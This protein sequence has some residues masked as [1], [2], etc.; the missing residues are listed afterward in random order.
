[1]KKGS[2]YWGKSIPSWHWGPRRSSPVLGSQV[3][4]FDINTEHK[5]YHGVGAV[6]A[7]P[8]CYFRIQ[9][10]ETTHSLYMSKWTWVRHSGNVCVSWPG[11]SVVCRCPIL[12]EGGWVL[13][14]AWSS[15]GIPWDSIVKSLYSPS[16][17]VTQDVPTGS[18]V[19][20]GLGGKMILLVPHIMQTQWRDN[21]ASSE[22]KQEHSI[23]A[24]KNEN[25]DQIQF[26]C[27]IYFWWDFSG[28]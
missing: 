13:G 27:E 23:H 19:E 25:P 28:P 21:W 22:T 5:T 16:K 15:L 12:R 18:N 26:Y 17:F 3:F 4:S 11:F 6:L 24:M 10:T 8:Y 1:M 2:F 7:F 9:Y 20:E 14:E